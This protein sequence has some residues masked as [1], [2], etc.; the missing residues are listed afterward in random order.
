MIAAMLL[1]ALVQKPAP[2]TADTARGR[3]CTVV[4]DSVRGKARQVQ[5]RK[6]ETNVFAGGGV[7]AHCGGTGSCLSSDSAAWFAGVGRLEMIGQKGPLQLRDRALTRAAQRA[8]Y[9][10]RL[11]PLGRRVK[12]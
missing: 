1:L 9:V 3:P 7:F 11:A 6:R 12:H 5:V 4:I 2:A 10:L 8:S